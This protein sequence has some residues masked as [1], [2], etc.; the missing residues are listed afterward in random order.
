MSKPFTIQINGE[1]FHC[2]SSMSIK[3]I[4]TYLDIDT[5]FSLIEYNSDL[6]HD[7]QIENILLNQND[8]LEILTIVG[9]G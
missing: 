6:L 9:G 1:P 8:K 7:D 2:T 5:T 4:L 3:D